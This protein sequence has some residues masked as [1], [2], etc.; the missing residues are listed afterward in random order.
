MGIDS[1]FPSTWFTVLG[2]PIKDTVVQTWIVMAVLA[3]LTLWAR[4]RYR[5]WEPEAWQLALEYLIEYIEGLIRSISGRVITELVPFL[6]TMISFIA[7]ANLL[8]LV[9]T[10]QA[11]TRD[12]NT[13]IALS[14]VSYGATQYFGWKKKGL[15]RH[16]KSF[17]EPVALMLP[18]NILGQL[19]RVLSMA[20]RLFGNVVAGEVI[21]AVFFMLLPVLSPLPMNLLGMITSVLQ[22][23]VFSVLTLVFVADAMGTDSTTV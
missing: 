1:V 4:Q 15:R 23:L 16:L 6:T 3:G 18:L 20:L 12:L 21:G 14:C 13:T 2:I 22:A 9:P 5:V 10:F 19:S 11:P 8:G 17:I 7:I